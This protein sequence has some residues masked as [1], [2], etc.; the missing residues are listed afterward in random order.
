[1]RIEL[2]LSR[3]QREVQ[4]TTLRSPLKSSINIA[5]KYYKYIDIDYL[6]VLAPLQSYVNDNLHLINNY[7]VNMDKN[8]I[9]TAAPDLP[10]IFEPMNL[11]IDSLAVIALFD[12]VSEIHIDVYKHVRINIPILNCN[13]SQT[14]FFK[15][16]GEPERRYLSNGVPYIWV[17]PEKCEHIDTLVLNK[18]AALRVKE[19]HQVIAGQQLPRISLTIKFNEVIDYLLDD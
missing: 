5:M 3:S 10:K 15:Y 17:D 2:I 4:A 11:S 6:R 16:S 7:W 1:M 9:F 14:K 12:T 18:P 13:D 19:P 8:A